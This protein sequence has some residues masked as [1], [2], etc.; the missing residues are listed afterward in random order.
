MN[1]FPILL[2]LLVALAGCGAGDRAAPW[3]LILVN[4]DRV[5][6][7]VDKSDVLSRYHISSVQDGAYKTFATNEHV[8]L[9]Y[10][11][12]CLNLSL[13]PGYTYGVS[14]TLNNKNYRY[15]FFIDN[16][17]NVQSTL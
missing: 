15:V 12:S 1:R 10:P 16:D 7:S 2:P 13:T 17:W 6:F 3:R 11:N 9:S 8:I 4:K 5:C 14:Y